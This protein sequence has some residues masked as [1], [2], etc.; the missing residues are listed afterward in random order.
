MYYVALGVYI[1]LV[2]GVGLFTAKRKMNIDEINV[3]NREVG[4]IRSAFSIAA[5]WTW[6][7]ALFVASERAYAEGLLGFWWF[8]IPNVLTLVVFGFVASGGVDRISSEHT[9]ADIMKNAYGSERIKWVYNVILI[10]IAVCAGGVQLLAGGSV[11]AMITGFPFFY[12]TVF[13]VITAMIYSIAGGIRASITTDFLQM[14]FIYGGIALVIMFLLPSANLQWG[15][16]DNV[17]THFLSGQNWEYFL[18]FGLTTTV[19][20][21]SGPYGDQMYWQ[22]VIAMDPKTVKKSFV[23]S[24]FLFAGI[25]LGISLLGFSSAG[26]GFVPE[27]QQMVGLEYVI[28]VAPPVV[29]A[30]FII[31]L[32][33]GLSSTLDSAMCASGAVFSSFSDKTKNVFSVR[34]GMVVVSV[35][36]VVL[37]NIPNMTIFWLFLA[38]G[39]MR[40]SVTI[41]TITTMLT[42]KVPSEGAIFW[43]IIAGLVIGWPT[44]LYGALN[45]IGSYSL[46][47]TLLAILLPAVFILYDRINTGKKQR[48]RGAK[49]EDTTQS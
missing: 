11:L 43:G 33:S 17:T 38:Y 8:F 39:V 7:P 23:L 13:L 18:A 28:A 40:S 32:M 10:I 19:G 31:A 5:S 29:V 25:P 46:L 34:V 9:I 26:A 15:G 2:L 42:K 1:L 14:G 49:N 45:G 41:P 35:M 6:A 20:L 48:M 30:V 37:A 16:I 4:W 22:R 44:Y 27:S 3:A 21:L 12:I 36:A 47:G 24:A